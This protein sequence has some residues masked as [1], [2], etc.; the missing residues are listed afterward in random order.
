MKIPF[1]YSFPIFIWLIL[2]QL[3][4]SSSSGDSKTEQQG[5]DNNPPVQV[6]DVD[7]WLTK[8]DKSAQLAKQNENISFNTAVNTYPNIEINEDQTF[9]TVDGFGFT[10][11]GGSVDAIN[12]LSGS[13]KTQLLEELFGSASNAI[14]ISYLRISI[15]A[16]DLNP[17]PFTYD[18]VAG[19]TT[20]EHFSL[21]PDSDL[22]AMLKQILTIN[23]NIKILGSPW[24]A[25]I[26][27]KDNNNSKGGSLLP[28]YYGT[29][30]QYFVKYIKAMAAEGITVDAI[31]IQNEPH[32]GGNNPSMVMNA[33]EQ[34]KFIRE[35]LGPAFADAGLQTK[36][37]VWDHNCD[38]PAYP[39]EVLRD[40]EANP[41]IDG[42]AF[43]LYAGDISAL[44]QVHSQFPNKNLYFTEQYTSSSGTFQ[45]DLSWHV[46]NVVIGSMRNWS[47]NALEWNLAND[48][49]FGPHTDGGCNTCKGGLTIDQG[50]NVVRN[51]GYYI[52]GHASKFVPAGSVRIGTNNVT[53]VSNVAFKTPEGKIVLIVENDSD[54][55]QT[56]NIKQNGEWATVSLSYG[57]VGTFVWN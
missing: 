24:S 21:E 35:N 54:S 42:S 31:T 9:Q 55:V 7:F 32:H 2:P 17:E 43:H 22:I 25:P 37:I 12:R 41:Y 30:A 51:V 13:A 36:I 49:N 48:E 52:I 47:K 46:K 11:T 50:G 3:N 16:S 4:C 40:T 18:D 44:S 34:A 33:P 28:E 57:A 19:D 56:F 8:G 5:D 10:L 27:M 20:L 53:G 26:W 23:P 38:E 6:S 1:R 45:G 14:G 15:G 39:I 29:Y